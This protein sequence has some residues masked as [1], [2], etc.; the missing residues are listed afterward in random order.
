MSADT[1]SSVSIMYTKRT[2]LQINKTYAHTAVAIDSQPHGHPLS[3]PIQFASSTNNFIQFSTAFNSIQLDKF[4][5]FHLANKTLYLIDNMANYLANY[6][7]HTMLYFVKRIDG[8]IL[9]WEP[10]NRNGVWWMMEETV[11][12]GWGFR[13][14]PLFQSVPCASCD[15]F[16]CVV[17]MMC[18]CSIK[19]WNP[20]RKWVLFASTTFVV[21]KCCR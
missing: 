7:Q 16:W 6:F 3:H 14:Y 17:Y 1:V 10:A 19:W 15:I 13:C 4:K 11:A 18:M 12:W 9:E 5:R 20:I 2:E 21:F 8:V